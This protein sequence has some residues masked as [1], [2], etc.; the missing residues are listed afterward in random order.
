MIPKKTERDDLFQV[1][2]GSFVSVDV[3]SASAYKKARSIHEAK[4]R[5]MESMKAQIQNI[6]TEMAEI[7]NLLIQMVKGQA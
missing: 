7:K 4:E 3:N 2:P 6:N 5:E 1:N